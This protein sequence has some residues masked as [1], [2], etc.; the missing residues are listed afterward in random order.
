MF[1]LKVIT[2]LLHSGLLLLH[3]LLQVRKVLVSLI[4]LA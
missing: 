1:F 4:E 2:S 3:F